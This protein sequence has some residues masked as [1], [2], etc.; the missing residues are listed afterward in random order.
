MAF[1][2]IGPSMRQET[3]LRIVRETL[4]LPGKACLVSRSA[5]VYF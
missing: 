2:A 4:A 1:K 5:A 3:T